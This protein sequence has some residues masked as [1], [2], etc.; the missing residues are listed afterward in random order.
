MKTVFSPHLHWPSLGGQVWAWC[1]KLRDCIIK[2]WLGPNRFEYESFLSSEDD[3]VYE[4]EVSNFQ[5]DV[6]YNSAVGNTMFL[7]R[8]RAC[9]QYNE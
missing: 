4:S 1:L 7:V 2:E 3:C 9:A 5:V 8:S 6:Y